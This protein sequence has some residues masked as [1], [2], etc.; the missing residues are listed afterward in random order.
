[1]VISSVESA[2]FEPLCECFATYEFICEFS[3][4]NPYC[5]YEFDIFFIKS[6]TNYRI[7][8]KIHIR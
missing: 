1:M 7:I 6:D 3:A 8:D 4:P 5:P 2:D